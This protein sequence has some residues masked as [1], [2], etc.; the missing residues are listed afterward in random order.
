[1]RGPFANAATN[2][3]CFALVHALLKSPGWQL[4]RERAPAINALAFMQEAANLPKDADPLWTAAAINFVLFDL[5]KHS[6]TFFVMLDET[7]KLRHYPQSLY[8]LGTQIHLW[9]NAI[10]ELDWPTWNREQMLEVFGSAVKYWENLALKSERKS[11]RYIHLTVAWRYARHGYD[12]FR[13]HSVNRKP[14]RRWAKTKN[15]LSHELDELLK[16]MTEKERLETM[17]SIRP[18]EL[19]ESSELP[20]PPAQTAPIESKIEQ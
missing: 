16:S 12:L 13:K 1:M 20:K 17:Q 7:K 11:D 4:Y 8:T 18:R 14:D 6:S 19:S 10:R 9:E 3:D 15:R 2:K 5:Y